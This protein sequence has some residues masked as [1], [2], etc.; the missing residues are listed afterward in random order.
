M[1]ESVPETLRFPKQLTLPEGIFSFV[2]EQRDG[3]SAVYRGNATYLRIGEPKRIQRALDLHRRMENDA[4]PVSKLLGEG[5]LGNEYYFIESSL[6]DRRFGDLFSDDIKQDG[7]ISETHF[8]ELLTIV[9]RFGE[10]QLKTVTEKEWGFFE[11]GL[12]LD[13]LRDELPEYRTK[14]DERFG[15]IKER[16][17]G[18]PFVLTHGDFNA[19]NLYPAGVI[20][21]EDSFNGPFGYDLM[22][23]LVHIG[24]FPQEDG[25]EYRAKYHFTE[26]Q[27]ARYRETMD[28]LSKKM[29]V[30]PISQFE[31]DFDFCRGAWS[32]VRMQKWPKL[33]QYRYGL[34]IKK[35]LS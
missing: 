26:Q 21:L 20:D 16:L 28:Q 2:V 25:Y 12:H 3:E 10:A 18:L 6:G 35:F 17:S 29:G 24:Y 4:F 14:I 8:N 15:R 30:V 1:S 13:I 34:F 5:T 19:N 11:K 27:A 23:A 7:E 32:L 33:Q 31:S 22:S 9:T